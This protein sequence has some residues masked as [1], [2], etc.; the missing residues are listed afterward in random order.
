MAR[1]PF[2]IP[3]L[4]LPASQAQISQAVVETIS[5]LPS[6]VAS[7]DTVSLAISAGSFA[8]VMD[9]AVDVGIELRDQLIQGL[10]DITEALQTDTTEEVLTQVWYKNTYNHVNLTHVLFGFL[11]ITFE[12]Q[13]KN[14]NETDSNLSLGTRLTRVKR[15]IRKRGY[16]NTGPLLAGQS[17]HYLVSHT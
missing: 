8:I 13:A 5:S 12:K 14:R 6:V 1:S 10:S 16:D 17:S 4:V 7:L 3:F 11:E 15:R 2:L 9:E